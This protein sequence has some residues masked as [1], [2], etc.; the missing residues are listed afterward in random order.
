MPVAR[1]CSGLQEV[2]KHVRKFREAASH[3]ACL[4]AALKSFVAGN[5]DPGSS[6]NFKSPMPDRLEHMVIVLKAEDSSQDPQFVL[7]ALKARTAL[8]RA[9]PRLMSSTASLHHI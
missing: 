2:V 5:E 7:L 8:V 9:P 1:R 6:P 4:L 3:K